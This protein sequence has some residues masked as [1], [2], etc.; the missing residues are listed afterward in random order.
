MDGLSVGGNWSS[1]SRLPHINVLELSAVFLPLTSFLPLLQG[2]VV[3][4]LTDNSTAVCYINRQ[5]GTVSQT[6]CRLALRM[7]TWCQAHKIFLI[8]THVPG[9]QNVWTDSLSRGDAPHHDWELNWTY[10][11]PLFLLWGHPEIDVFASRGNTKCRLFCSRGGADPDS[12]RDGLLLSWKHKHHYLFPPVPLLTWVVNKLL[13]ERPR[14]ILVTPWWPRRMVS[15]PSPVHGEH[16]LSIPTETGSPIGPRGKNLTSRCSALKVDCLETSLAG[17]PDRIRHVLSH[18]RKSSTTKSYNSKW[19][20][21]LL[22][23]SPDDPSPGSIDFHHVLSYLLS[24]AEKGLSH[25]SIRVHLSAISAH[26]NRVEGFSVL[27]P[28]SSS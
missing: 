23:V 27:G 15:R 6:L 22:A 28:T 13:Q 7:W 20:R 25:S 14:V 24:L 2:K 21:F 19:K 4:I 8:A 10:L 12:L 9:L 17:F 18:S 11:R 16:L 1:G 26:L 5:G 3:S